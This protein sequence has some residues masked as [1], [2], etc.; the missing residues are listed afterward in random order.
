MYQPTQVD[1]CLV[2]L[3]V[4][5]PKGTIR[6]QPLANLD[7]NK[8]YKLLDLVNTNLQVTLATWS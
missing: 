7:K 4:M 3:E 1:F 6:L 8:N 5:E 2:I